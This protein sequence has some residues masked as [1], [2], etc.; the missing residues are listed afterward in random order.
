MADYYASVEE[1]EQAFATV[2]KPTISF[3]W[4]LGL[5]LDG[6]HDKTTGNYI[7]R[8]SSRE[9]MQRREKLRKEESDAVMQMLLT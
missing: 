5:E 6:V 7:H 1:A 9:E 3:D 4:A 8:Y 2:T